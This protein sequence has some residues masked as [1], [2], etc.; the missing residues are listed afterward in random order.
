MTSPLGEARR[1]SAIVGAHYGLLCREVVYSRPHTVLKH[2]NPRVA[3]G[4]GA[5]FEYASGPYNPILQKKVEDPL[6]L[7]FL[8][9]REGLRSTLSSR[10]LFLLVIEIALTFI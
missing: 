10:S 6:F 3:A 4:F 9:L 8:P 5:Q 7:A 2:P 1:V